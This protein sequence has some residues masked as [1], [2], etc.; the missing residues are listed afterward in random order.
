MLLLFIIQLSQLTIARVVVEYAAYAAARSAIVWIPADLGDELEGPNRMGLSR[1]W[2]GT[3]EDETGQLFARYSLSPPSRKWDR[4]HLAAVQALMSVCPSRDVG[5]S[6]THPGMQA[7]TSLERSYR[8]LDPNAPNNSQ[9]PNRLI[10]KLAY[11]LSATSIQIEIRHKETEPPLSWHDLR[12]YDE[13]FTDNEIGWQD[14]ILVTLRHVFELLPGPARLL[15]GSTPPPGQN[16]DPVSRRI[17][18]RPGVAVYP[19]TATAR[20]NNEGEKQILSYVQR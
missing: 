15:A 2:L 16:I 6:R 17:E 10:N 14:L 4:S 9:I 13:E 5:A 3:V 20:F 18:Q 8:A 12:P 11:A 7:A 19:L 1:Q